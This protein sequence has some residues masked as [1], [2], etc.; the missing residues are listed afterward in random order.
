MTLSRDSLS[1]QNSLGRQSGA[2]SSRALST[3]FKQL[4]KLDREIGE[5]DRYVRVHLGW[6]RMKPELIERR[7]R[8]DAKRRDVRLLRKGTLTAQ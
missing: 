8:L 5:I 4:R 3:I 1:G 7:K 2:R 6:V